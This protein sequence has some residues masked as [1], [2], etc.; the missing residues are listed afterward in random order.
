MV[1]LQGTDIQGQSS[2]DNTGYLW[3]KNLSSGSYVIQAYVD[4]IE[5]VSPSSMTITI[6]SAGVSSVSV[7][8][9][10]VTIGLAQ[11]TGQVRVSSAAITTGALVVVTT[12]SLGGTSASMPPSMS[13]LTTTCSPCYFAGSSDSLG[14]YAIDV[15][16]HASAYN[17]Y[18]WYTTFSGSTPTTT[19]V[20]PFSVTVSTP[21]VTATQNLSW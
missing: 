16:S 5:V 3:I 15:R 12:S 2:S 6:S 14:N 10:T 7:A 11:V 20:G 19:R 9:F 8:T 17:V 18:G 21:G 1:A 13:S 4:P